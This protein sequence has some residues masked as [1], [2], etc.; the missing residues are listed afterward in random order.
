MRLS[1]AGIIDAGLFYCA[2]LAQDAC[3]RW[4]VTTAASRI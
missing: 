4:V 1:K 2:K 3:F